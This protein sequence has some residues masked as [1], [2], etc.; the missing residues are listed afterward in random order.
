MKLHP[1]VLESRS[2]LNTCHCLEVYKRVLCERALRSVLRGLARKWCVCVCVC[3]WCVVC[4][5]VF[6]WCV[7]MC[8]CLV[9]VCVCVRVF[10]WCVVCVCVFSWC[11]VCVCVYC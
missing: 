9:G 11:V 8:A 5:C 1:S 4:V 6:S 3:S 7:C 2:H 10:S